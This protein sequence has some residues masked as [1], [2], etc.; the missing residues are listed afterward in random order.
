VAGE[1]GATAEAG[2]SAPA[3]QQVDGLLHRANDRLLDLPEGR[4]FDISRRVAVA[5]RLS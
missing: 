1:V 3:L 4:R 2:R 5:A